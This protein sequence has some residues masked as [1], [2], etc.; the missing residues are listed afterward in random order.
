[1][2]RGKGKGGCTLTNSHFKFEGD[3]NVKEFTIAMKDLRALA[4]SCGEEF[5]CYYNDELYYFYPKTNKQQCTKWALIVDEIV[6]G[7]DINE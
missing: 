6:K 1:M 5:E 7:E 2:R 4:F 3:L